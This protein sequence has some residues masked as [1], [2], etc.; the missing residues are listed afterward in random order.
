MGRWHLAT[1]RSLGARVVAV[2]DR[3][4]DRARL[5]SRHAPAAHIS[6]DLGALKRHR[7]AAA[8]V[9][10]PTHTHADYS[11]GLAELGVHAFVEKPLATDAHLTKRIL[12]AAQ[13]AGVQICPVHQYAFQPGV[14]RALRA[15][16][17]IGPIHSVDFSICSAGAVSG[18]ISPAELVNEILPHPISI[19]QRLLPG[20]QLSRLEWTVLRS[21]PGEMLATAKHQTVL[22]SIFVSAHARPTSMDTRIRCQSGSIEINGFHG[23]AVVNSG[24]VSRIAKIRH[25]FVSSMRTLTVASSNLAGRSLRGEPAYPGLRSLMR[26]FYSSVISDGSTPP[27]IN[28]A[29][30]LD[31]AVVRDILSGADDSTNRRGLS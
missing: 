1:A 31:G 10:T 3:D 28:A 17:R 6:T 16:E 11:I 4:L 26:R 14:D 2:V 22:L 30:I 18:S 15:V 21:Q 25:P 7:V 27:P 12:D 29:S 19:L 20:A 8:H 23:Y 9:C 13:L 24:D 5:L